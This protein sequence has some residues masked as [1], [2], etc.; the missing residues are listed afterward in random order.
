MRNWR[1]AIPLLLLASGCAAH[2]Q[3]TCAKRPR[4]A[5]R[6]QWA[7]ARKCPEPKKVTLESPNFGF[8]ILP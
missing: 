7:D 2:V 1:L 5:T 8:G 6:A 4:M 3:D